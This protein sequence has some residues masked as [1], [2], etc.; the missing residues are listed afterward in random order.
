MSSRR[1]LFSCLGIYGEAAFAHAL[2]SPGPLTGLAAG[3]MVHESSKPL[4]TNLKPL[5]PY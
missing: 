2:S 3:A 4:K 1:A 5:K